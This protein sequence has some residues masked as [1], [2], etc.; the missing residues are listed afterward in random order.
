MQYIR[1]GVKMLVYGSSE[2]SQS[3]APGARRCQLVSLGGR[4]LDR[5]PSIR[6]SQENPDYQRGI[7]TQNTKRG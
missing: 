7:E 5:L 1:S 6:L 3:E 2:D 4:R